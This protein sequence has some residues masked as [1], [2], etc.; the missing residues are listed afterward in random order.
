LSGFGIGIS[1]LWLIRSCRSLDKGVDPDIGPF[2]V[3]QDL[4]S[5]R[6]LTE[7]LAAPREDLNDVPVLKTGISDSRLEWLYGK[8]AWLLLQL[9]QTV[10][11]RIGAL[12]GDKPRILPGVGATA[13][14]KHE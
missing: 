8:V 10:F 9:A 12:V 1:V 5:P 6:A 7:A 4:R 11:P 3:I 2:I 14:S 13:H